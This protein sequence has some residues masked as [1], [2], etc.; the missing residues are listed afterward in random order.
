MLNDITLGQYYPAESSIHQLDPRTKLL[1]TFICMTI[2]LIIGHPFALLVLSLGLYA[3]I[4]SSN[5]PPAF[6]LRNLKPFLWL[7]VLTI[8][9]HIIFS[10]DPQS[11]NGDHTPLY[12]I[13]QG[14]FRGITYSLRLCLLILFAAILTLTTSPIEITDALEKLLTPM[15]KIGLPVHD[16]TMMITL[17]LRF[18]PTLILE[19]DKLRKA[20]ISRGMK[21]KGN[22]MKRVHSII[23]LLLPLFMSVFRRADELAMAMDA[24][25]Y[26]GGEERTRFK[27]LEFKSSDYIVISSAVAL[28]LIA[29]LIRFFN[30]V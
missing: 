1:V 7:F 3:I 21:F 27:Q 6:V 15:K 24:R 10:E 18:I 12:V 13:R 28:L 30:I 11:L 4:K 16:V 29:V 5:I 8:L 26:T 19:A 23:P 22:L 14:L 20:Q 25:C 9:I 2:M 17:S